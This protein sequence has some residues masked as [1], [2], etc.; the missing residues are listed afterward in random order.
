MALGR[1]GL[2]RACEGQQGHAAALPPLLVRFAAR[3]YIPSSLFLALQ[4]HT[5]GRPTGAVF[6]KRNERIELMGASEEVL[7]ELATDPKWKDTEIVS[8]G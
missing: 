2:A 7:R 6:D 4:V 8:G 1:A 5:R 3:T